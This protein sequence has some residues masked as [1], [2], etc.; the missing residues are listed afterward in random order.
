MI[1][2]NALVKSATI[3]VDDHGCLTAWVHL[4]YGDSRQGFGGYMLYVPKREN[5]STGKFLWRVME[6]VG[7]SSWSD[8]C[9][10]VIRVR[11]DG[12]SIISIGNAIEDKWFT[13][14]AELN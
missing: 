3:D 5:D 12:Q 10:K 13:P 11:S 14:A 7:V 8:L 2:R 9:G 4:D 1:Q 6:V